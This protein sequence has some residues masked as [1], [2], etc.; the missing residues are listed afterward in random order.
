MIEA[1]DAVK[2]VETVAKNI[3]GV[4]NNKSNFARLP[5]T[6]WGYY[7]RGHDSKGKFGI[8]VT[9]SENGSDVDELIKIYEQW[10]AKNKSK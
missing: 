5:D 1:E 8:I 2:V 9:Y 7:A 3:I 10:L 6:Y 4:A